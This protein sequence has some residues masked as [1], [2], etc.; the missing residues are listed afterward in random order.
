MKETIKVP[1]LKD[2]EIFQAACKL[3]AIK[4]E[5]TGDRQYEVSIH[6]STDL[7]YLGI[8]VGIGRMESNIVTNVL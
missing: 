8:L 1:T 4:F 2:G 3:M 7:Y 6:G 5:K